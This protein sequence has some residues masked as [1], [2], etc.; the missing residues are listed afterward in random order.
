MVWSFCW[1]KSGIHRFVSLPASRPGLCPFDESVFGVRDLEGSIHEPTTGRTKERRQY[2]VLR[3]GAWEAEDEY[4]FRVDTRVG[5]PPE[6]RSRR[7]G[8]RLIAELDRN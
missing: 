2:I 6:T 5:F 4:E 8:I 7:I 1:N 3:G